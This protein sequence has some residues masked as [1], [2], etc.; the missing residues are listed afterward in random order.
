MDV[1]IQIFTVSGKL[2]R[3]IVTRTTTTGF[4]SNGIEWDGK[5]DFGHNIGRGV[6]VYHLKLRAGDGSTA[7]KYE[8]LVILY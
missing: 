3:N 4:R 7:D 2:V 5:D 1:Q 6:Y 8:K